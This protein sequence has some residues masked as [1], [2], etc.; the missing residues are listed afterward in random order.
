MQLNDLV[1]EI[2]GVQG[3]RNVLEDLEIFAG[4]GQDIFPSFG[5]YPQVTADMASFDVV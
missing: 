1:K 4:Q 5:L 3:I 2:M